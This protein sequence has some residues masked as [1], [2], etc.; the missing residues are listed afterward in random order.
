VEREIAQVYSNWGYIYR[1]KG[2]LEQALHYYQQALEQGG[3]QKNIARTLNNIGFV[4]FLNGDTEK[5]VTYVGKALHMRQQLGIAYESGLSNNTL[6]MIMENMGRVNEAANLFHKAYYYFEASYSD[7]G[8]AL[9]QI[10]LG[11]LYRHAHDFD[12]AF[13]Y[14]MAARKVL[15]AKGDMAYLSV[16]LNEIGCAYRQQATAK[17]RQ[18]AEKYL[19]E[20]LEL[21]RK[22]DNHQSIADNLEDLHIL[23]CQWGRDLKKQGNLQEAEEYFRKS[24]ECGR[25]AKVIAELQRLTNILAKV[26]RT[27]G[28]IDFERQDYEKAF[29]HFFTACELMAK[30]A[31]E[32]GGYA[33][34]FQRRLTENASR[35]QQRLQA[36]PQQEGTQYAKKILAWIEN[37]PQEIRERLLVL[38]TFLYETL[39][40][41]QYELAPVAVS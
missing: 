17:A 33:L 14:L 15:E 2:Q 7:R 9:A 22:I 13:H 25:E 20:S 16:T 32:K 35:L 23:Y 24:E 28:D 38:Q 31:N 41:N 21:S 5:A 3:S 40:L 11:R 39:Q 26:E 8:L 30:A 29:W 37:L 34:Q 1:V 19:L 12:K 36:L 27:A 4:H 6:G 10:N 18:L